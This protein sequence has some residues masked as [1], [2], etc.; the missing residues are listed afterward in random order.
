MQ[1]TTKNAA[2]SVALAAAA[3]L[4][5]TAGCSTK[6]QPLT[7]AEKDKFNA[8]LGQPMPPEAKAAMARMQQ[9]AAQKMQQQAQQPPPGP[10]R[11]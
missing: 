4:S 11:Q 8:P 7:Q 1:M 5:L 9:E 2:L 3:L 6:A 10:K